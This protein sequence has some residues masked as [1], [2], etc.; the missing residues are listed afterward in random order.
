MPFLFRFITCEY[1]SEVCSRIHMFWGNPDQLRI[2]L[3]SFTNVR[4]KTYC[5]FLSDALA[6]SKIVCRSHCNRFCVL[7][8]KFNFAVQQCHQ[9]PATQDRS[10]VH[11]LCRNFKV[12]TTFNECHRCLFNRLIRT[13]YIKCSPKLDGVSTS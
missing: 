3:G 8:L 1:A 6:F 4:E 7:G 9:S 11:R 2:K 12:E 13:D 10:S 5:V